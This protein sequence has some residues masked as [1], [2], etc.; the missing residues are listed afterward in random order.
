M[1]KVILTLLVGLVTLCTSAQGFEPEIRVGYDLGVDTYKNTSFGGKFTAGYRFNPMFR[2]GA[3]VGMDYVDL[4]YE[5]AHF[6]KYDYRK[7]YYESAMSV[8]LFLNAKVN[9]TDNRV[10]PF[11]ATDFGYNIFIPCSDYAEHNSLGIFVA[12]SFG[13]DIRAGRGAFIIQVGYKYQA[14]DFDGWAKTNGNYSQVTFSTGY[15]F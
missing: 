7:K 6:T 3:G 13:I 11:F 15:Q 9:F 2:F 8:P 10:S 14:R 1:K 5:N 4:F 12:P